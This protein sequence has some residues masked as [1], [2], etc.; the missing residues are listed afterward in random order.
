MPVCTQCGD[1]HKAET[2]E[3]FNAQAAFSSSHL[4]IGHLSATVRDAME[5]NLS[6]VFNCIT[7]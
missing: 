3:P 5:V 2:E 6:T 4:K 1:T 7:E